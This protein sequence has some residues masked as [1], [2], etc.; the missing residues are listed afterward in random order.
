MPDVTIHHKDAVFLDYIDDVVVSHPVTISVGRNRQDKAFRNTTS[1][2]A[3]LI[4][5]L[6][7]F[8]IGP[9]DG[10]CIVSGEVIGGQR[11]ANNMR[12]NS[13]LM[14]DI[15]N[16][17]SL[18]TMVQKAK[19]AGL[20]TIIWTTHS[21]NKNTSSVKESVLQ[22]FLN[23]RRQALAFED[24]DLYVQVC[25]YLRDKKH[26]ET[27]VLQEGK[28]L[29]RE[30]NAGG[31]EYVIEHAPMP[32]FRALFVLAAPYSFSEGGPQRARIEGWRTRYKRFCEALGVTHD[33]SCEDPSR[34][35]YTP[36]KATR[37][38]EGAIYVVPGTLLSLEDY[39]PQTNAFIDNV[40]VKQARGVVVD[41][42]GVARYYVPT[43]PDLLAFARGAADFNAVAAFE[44]IAPDDV[45][46]PAAQGNGICFTC[47][48]EDMHTNPSPDDKAFFITSDPTGGTEGKGV[49]YMGC[50]HAGC[51]D[52]SKGDRLWYLDKL[53]SKYGLTVDDLT[54][55][56][57]ASQACTTEEIKTEQGARN[58]TEVK[59]AYW[60]GIADRVR[61]VKDIVDNADKNDP[62][63][64]EEACAVI[65]QSTRI[66]QI[67]MTDRLAEA[68]GFGK[69]AI[70]LLV[71]DKTQEY[72]AF[73]EQY[74][75]FCEAQN[76][77]KNTNGSQNGDGATQNNNTGA[78]GAVAPNPIPSDLA[79]AV[80]IW[81]DW[82]PRVIRDA[83][84]ARVAKHNAKKP[85]VFKGADNMP[86]RVIVTEDGAT[87]YA[88][89][90]DTARN[91]LLDYLTF[92]KMNVTTGVA[93]TIAPP[94]DL[95]AGWVKDHDNNLPR[96]R[97]VATTPVFSP[98]GTLQVEGGYVPSMETY[99]VVDK[100]D[101]L[102]VAAPVS[103]DDLRTAWWWMIEAIRDFPFTD[104][105]NGE[106]DLPIKLSE[107]DEDNFPLPNLERGASSRMN[108]I[109][110][111]LQTFCRSM[112]DGPCPAFFIDK[113]APGTGAGY[114]ANVASVIATGKTAPTTPMSEHN[115]EFRKALTAAISECAPIIFIDNVNSKV[116]S[117]DFASA[118]TTGEWRDRILG[119][120][121]MTHFKVRSSWIIT[122]NNISFSTE[123]LRRLVPVRLDSNTPNPA[124][125]RDQR[126]FKH[127]NLTQ[128]LKE[129]RQHL[130]WAC[131]VIIQAWVDAGMPKDRAKHMDLNSFVEW[132]EVMGGIFTTSARLLDTPMIGQFMANQKTFAVDADVDLETDDAAVQD[133]FKTYGH[134][135]EFTIDEAI[136]N[137][138]DIDGKLKAIYPINGR[139]EDGVRRSFGKWVAKI[140]KRTFIMTDHEGHKRRVKLVKRRT[141]A[142]SRYEFMIVHQTGF[143]GD[144]TWEPH[145]TTWLKV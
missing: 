21:H 67:S 56:S 140:T 29:R 60:E 58:E 32:R 46:G 61:N 114:L 37:E 84:L 33:E 122:G 23:K 81:M 57:N 129:N 118:L 109:A 22:Q 101:W 96:V 52:E 19:H 104:D 53:C 31:V 76:N 83:M 125:D 124:A 59:A 99:L 79:D 14:L 120:T 116:D 87:M 131:H 72:L 65:S 70:G 51:K 95:V 24:D 105:F 43:T 63:S 26:Y 145:K 40:N 20:L 142:G 41:G 139:N 75:L 141:K 128:W 108:A 73:K 112:I 93:A 137:A 12:A 68:T 11:L 4:D 92:K 133:L 94:K 55:F 102:P 97:S 44:T 16:G 143:N 135:V 144:Q 115:E 78:Q 117:G 18:E 119:Q 49:W 89:N 138:T 3:N 123:N 35:M 136:L 132:A 42:E 6:A 106:D 113:A 10:R 50:L 66:L 28:F 17:M 13:V 134:G 100:A 48:N 121:Q 88:L 2:V 30:H 90:V 98:D 47:P 77:N 127:Y 86:S 71:K 64:I 69:R 85:F 5:M 1:T 91:F 39:A 111:I 9:K 82:P 15:D 130:V 126:D 38:S 25:D 62:A 27:Y 110:L 54:P 7:E 107:L 36:R 8:E 74:K 34:L 103:T 80:E 45:R